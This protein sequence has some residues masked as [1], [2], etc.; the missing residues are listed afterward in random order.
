MCVTSYVR[1]EINFPECLA[2][3]NFVS[4]LINDDLVKEVKSITRKI[5]NMAGTA[6]KL[7]KGGMISKV[8]AAEICMKSKCSVII[9]SGLKEKPIRSLSNKKTKATKF[10]AKS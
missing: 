5:R 1:F 7:G 9:T 2:S 4:A 6:N 10:I 8:K 3:I